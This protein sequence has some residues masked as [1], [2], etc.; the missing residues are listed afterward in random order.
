MGLSR[1]S[2]RFAL[3]CRGA[4]MASLPRAATAPR[5]KKTESRAV[6]PHG[7]RRIRRGTGADAVSA[8]LATV[9]LAV[10][11]AASGL[12]REGADLYATHC[13][14]CHGAQLDGSTLAP[15]LKNVGAATVDFMLR[16]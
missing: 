10:T 7:R 5:R 1:R 12:V 13:G 11:L 8:F 9:L 15:P 4:C 16:T 3:H 2:H 14:F 6:G